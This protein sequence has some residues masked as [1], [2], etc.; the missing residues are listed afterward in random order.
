MTAICFVLT[1]VML[2]VSRL[3]TTALGAPFFVG[4]K[5]KFYLITAHVLKPD[6]NN[7]NSFS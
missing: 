6:E 1:T 2:H 7:I 4:A 5:V 3:R